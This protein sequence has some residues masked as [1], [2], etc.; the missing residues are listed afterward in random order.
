MKMAGRSS[1]AAYAYLLA[2]L[3]A[4]IFLFLL[5][6]TK[7]VFFYIDGQTSLYDS[8]GTEFLLLSVKRDIL[9]NGI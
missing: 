1:G 9:C 4:H 5:Q 2:L 8:W 3:A 7:W 6:F